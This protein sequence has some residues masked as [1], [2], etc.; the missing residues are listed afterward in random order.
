MKYLECKFNAEPREAGLDVRLGSHVIPKRGSFK[1]HGSVIQGDEKIDENVTH[2]I[3]V[4]W[5]KWSSTFRVLCDN[6]V[7]PL[8][9]GK[10]YRA[11]VRPAM[12]YGTECW[13][14]KKSH[15]QKMK[16]AEMR[17]LR[18]MYVHTKM[19]KIRNEDIGEKVGVAPMDDQMRET[20]LR[21]FGH[22]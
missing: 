12:L 21:W 14:I 15:I 9:K 8:P 13:P 3:G 17:M 1:C 7:P 16:V 22:V 18:W 19:D 6:K 11:V 20:T 5:M 10:F 4:G 2:S